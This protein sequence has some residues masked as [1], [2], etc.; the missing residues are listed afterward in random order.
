[1]DEGMG[2]IKNV[3]PSREFIDEILT[4]DVK[5]LEATSGVTLSKFT[6]A[7]S[8]YLVYFKSEVNKTRV[9]IHRKQRFLDNSVAQLLSKDMIKQYKSKAAA[10]SAIVSNTKMY[11]EMS[12]EVGRLKDE[13]V[14][15]DGVDKTISELIAAFDKEWGDSLL[16]DKCQSM[17]FDNSK[18]KNLVPDFKATIPFS[19][20][21]REIIQWFDA[22]SSRQIVDENFNQ[23]CDRIIAA[24]QS[25]WPKT[26]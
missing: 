1:M 23:L 15:V 14:L 22:D 2:L 21:A 20:G 3:N 26:Q 8:Q 9:E 4:F 11:T 7:L 18:I 12:E 16:S 5:K 10:Y 6:I 17:I 24:Y 13:L 19:E 25:A